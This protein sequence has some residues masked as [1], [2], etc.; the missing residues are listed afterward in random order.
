MALLPVRESF[1]GL[2]FEAELMLGLLPLPLP[3]LRLLVLDLD[4][5]DRREVREAEEPPEAE[6]EAEDAEGLAGTTARVELGAPTELRAVDGPEE[7]GT[8]LEPED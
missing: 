2:V 8:D 5:R 4:R 6:R 7:Q 1:R 3:P